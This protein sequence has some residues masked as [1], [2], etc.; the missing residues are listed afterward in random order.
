MV[1]L[2][3]S[4]LCFK[5][6]AF[7]I[8]EECLPELDAPFL[9]SLC[10]FP[11]FIS[12]KTFSLILCQSENLSS[13]KLTFLCS[14]KNTLLGLNFAGIKLRGWPYPR[15]LNIRGYL[16]SRIV[17][18]QVFRGF[19]GWRHRTYEEF[20]RLVY[21]VFLLSKQVGILVIK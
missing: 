11:Y 3:L 5:S 19:C 15:N 10:M 14:K 8:I 13:G 21:T 17:Y 18:F 20:C 1:V 12:F 4:N 16:I 6:S 9:S 2:G 7:C